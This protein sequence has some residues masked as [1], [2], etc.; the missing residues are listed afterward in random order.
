M[1]EILSVTEMIS[2]AEA[3][4]AGTVMV[5]VIPAGTLSGMDVP[6]EAE[7]VVLSL[8][9]RA[10]VADPLRTV[11]PPEQNATSLPAFTAEGP[12]LMVTSSEAEAVHPLVPV[13][14]T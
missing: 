12:G 6:G 4:L 5:E 2:P 3:Q 13:T 1:C 10:P 8:H 7:Y 11:L 14:T 9:K